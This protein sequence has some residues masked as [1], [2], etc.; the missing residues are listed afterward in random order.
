MELEEL[1]LNWELLN[2][3]LEKNE[4]LN[5]RIIHEM[6]QK[7]TI[8]TYNKLFRAE[9]FC[10]SLGLVVIPVF[11]ILIQFVKYPP[12][13][14]WRI[15]ILILLGSTVIWTSFKLWWLKKFDLEN[16]D[17]FQLSQIIYTYRNWIQKECI[18]SIPILVTLLTIRFITIHA[19]NYPWL[20]ILIISI[21]V[22]STIYL[23]T[24]YRLFYKKHCN[25]IQKSLDEL[26]EFK[27]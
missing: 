19:Q 16:N 25:D 13:M 9:I 8:T 3:R 1:K 14:P 12:S 7:R 27:E 20:A 4:I 17:I 2:K 18:L 15:T 5:K 24:I 6:L 11:L 26:K 23:L 10:L 22:L 21:A